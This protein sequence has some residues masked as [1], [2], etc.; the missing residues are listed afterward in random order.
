V[1]LEVRRVSG[2]IRKDQ[3]YWG[4][5]DDD[6]GISS[7]VFDPDGIEVIDNA[8]RG[9]PPYIIFEFKFRED[10]KITQMSEENEESK[11]GIRLTPKPSKRDTLALPAIGRAEGMFFVKWK[12]HL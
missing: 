2:Q 4:K 11:I 8:A 10:P 1:R 9:K 7:C 6:D 5:D 3:V 12:N